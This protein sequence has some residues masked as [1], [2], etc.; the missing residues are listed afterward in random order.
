MQAS[1]FWAA[2]SDSEDEEDAGSEE[3]EVSEEESSSDDEGQEQKKGPSKCARSPSH[4]SALYFSIDHTPWSV[5]RAI[6]QLACSDLSGGS[7]WAA[8]HLH[9]G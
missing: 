8:G 9:R 3:E 5:S 1:R 4:A 2:G 7:S 6:S